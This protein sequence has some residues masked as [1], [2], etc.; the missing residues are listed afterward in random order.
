VTL[1]LTGDE[2]RGLVTHEIAMRA[3]WAVLDA[4]RQGA[5]VLP[6][7]I[8]VDVPTG[9]L[10]SM[11]AA[12]PPYMGLKVMSLARGVGNRY[13]ILVYDQESGALVAVLDAA[14]A[15]QLRTAATTAVAA[16]LLAPDGATELGLLGSGWEATGH[17]QTF[18]RLWPLQRVY[19]HSPNQQRREAFAER[20]SDELQLEVVPVDSAEETVAAVPVTLLC[21]KAP[22]PVIDGTAFPAG[23]VVLS[24]GSTRPDLRELDEATMRRSAVL[25]VDDPRLVPV[26]SGDIAEGL[27]AGA[28]RHEHIVAMASYQSTRTGDGR[29]L[30]SFKSVGTALQDLAL[31]AELIPAARQAGVGREIGELMA[32]KPPA[33]SRPNPLER[34]T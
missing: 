20:M 26:E 28:L 34:T 18:A 17:L 30:L 9:F 15:T 16:E 25:L 4:E 6:A 31:A 21:T 13:L 19:I 7:R 12:L 32:L 24:I 5:T 29:D 1:H 8:D 2:V 33:G 3:A 14:E 11:P 23:A 22:A 27:R 10:R